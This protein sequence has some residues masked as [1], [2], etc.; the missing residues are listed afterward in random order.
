MMLTAEAKARTSPQW[1]SSTFSA[2]AVLGTRT[3]SG[4]LPQ[5]AQ[6]HVRSTASYDATQPVIPRRLSLPPPLPCVPRQSSCSACLPAVAVAMGSAGARFRRRTRVLGE[7]T[8]EVRDQPRVAA[9]ASSVAHVQAACASAGQP[10]ESTHHPV[11]RSVG[12]FVRSGGQSAP[13]FKFLA[14]AVTSL[15][16][17]VFIYMALKLW[18]IHLIMFI[19]LQGLVYFKV[20]YVV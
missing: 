16:R 1:P 10:C 13:Q 15:H 11:G 5:C 20:L 19:I 17:F 4:W 14:L 9:D 12:Q 6:R 2:Q 18:F 8:V 7:H 3:A